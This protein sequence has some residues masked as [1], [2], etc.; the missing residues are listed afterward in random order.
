MKVTGNTGL[1]ST[2]GVSN[3]LVRVVVMGVCVEVII[4]NAVVDVHHCV[5]FHGVLVIQLTGDNTDTQSNI[6]L[7]DK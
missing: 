5:I 4:G 6:I 1:T 3:H 2:S 7:L